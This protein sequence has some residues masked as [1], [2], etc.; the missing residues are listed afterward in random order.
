MEWSLRVM[1]LRFRYKLGF[2][3]LCREATDSLAWHRFCRIPL[4][5]SV[6]H[7]STL[8]KILTRTGEAAVAG[9]TEALL[10]KSGG[11]S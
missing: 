2:E 7:P 10:A 5:V 9:L 6:P 11:V 4:G 1:F 8:E 3:A